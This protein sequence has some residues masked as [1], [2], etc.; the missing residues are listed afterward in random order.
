MNVSSLLFFDEI[1][2]IVCGRDIIEGTYICPECTLEYNDGGICERCGRAMNNAADYC[3][4][5]KS[6][7]SYFETGRSP[8]RYED[9][10]KLLIHR[11]KFGGEKFLSRALASLMYMTAIHNRLHCDC[12][13]PVPISAQRK[14]ERGFDQV[15]EIAKFLSKDTGKPIVPLLIKIK[16]TPASFTET[17]AEREKRIKG[18]IAINRNFDVRH[19]RIMLVDDIYTTGTTAQECSRLI[20]KAGADSVAVLAASSVPQHVILY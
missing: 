5:C 20:L 12:I 14:K 15:M 9:G 10:A 6:R 1:R 11:Y 17:R 18:S 2:C 13:V 7:A 19:K 4:T 8:L 16:D 3:E